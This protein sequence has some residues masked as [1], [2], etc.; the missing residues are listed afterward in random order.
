MSP[1]RSNPLL[2]EEGKIASQR[3]STLCVIILVALFNLESLVIDS[4][5]MT[6]ERYAI[7]FPL[8]FL[9]FSPTFLFAKL[10]EPD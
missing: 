9:F 6:N 7:S 5:D 2:S 4:E 8:H 10:F 3:V 1:E